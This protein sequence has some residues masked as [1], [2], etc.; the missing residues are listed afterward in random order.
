MKEDKV[1]PRKTKSRIYSQP[2]QQRQQ[3]QQQLAGQ[4]NIIRPFSLPPPIAV[5]VDQSRGRQVALSFS[6]DVKAT[7]SRDVNVQIVQN[8]QN[9]EMT[10]HPA[11]S[12][13]NDGSVTF[14][15]G[16]G[17]MGTL[18]FSP[19]NQWRPTMSGL[20]RSSPE[21]LDMVRRM[22]EM[23]RREILERLLPNVEVSVHKHDDDDWC[24]CGYGYEFLS[25]HEAKHK[26]HPKLQVKIKNIML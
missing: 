1:S 12:S 7:T 22:I 3:K 11:Y 8:G 20:Y 2:A 18:S 26:A 25:Q 5:T 13:S 19:R 14:P 9:T 16:N 23:R 10:S 4:S 15:V 6:N 17:L 24:T 21:E